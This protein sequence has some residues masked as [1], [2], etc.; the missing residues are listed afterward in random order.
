MKKKI[1]VLV[2]SSLL[3]CL[4][5]GLAPLLLG[6]GNQVLKTVCNIG[7]YLCFAAVA[8]A[9]MKI[10]GMKVELDWKNGRQYL[11]GTCIALALSVCI[12]FLPAKLGFSLVGGRMDF[13][14]GTLVFQ[15]FYY[16]LVIGPVEELV[17]RVYIQDTLVSLLGGRGRLGAVLAALLFGFWHWFNGNFVQVLFTFGIG[18][19]FGLARHHNKNLKLPGLA[20]G[21]GLYDFL[22]IVV[23]MFVV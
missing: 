3:L 21:H 9:A 18:L 19:V 11:V 7:I 8:L 15:F 22:N 5:T 12:A 6:I 2:I 4:L 14:L 16:C 10:T 23:R 1:A 13:H 17:F 20:L